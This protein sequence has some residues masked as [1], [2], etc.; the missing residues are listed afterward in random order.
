MLIYL[1]EK[2]LP[3]KPGSRS[4]P[5]NPGPPGQP[6]EKGERGFPGR[7]GNTGD[8]GFRGKK[9]KPKKKKHLVHSSLLYI[10]Y[11]LHLVCVKCMIIFWIPL[12]PWNKFKKD[13]LKPLWDLN[14]KCHP[15]GIF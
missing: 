11:N 3:G 9:G 7:Y 15:L 5:G 8:P 6:G 12:W 4:I 1:G 2:G 10:F 14:V 13:K